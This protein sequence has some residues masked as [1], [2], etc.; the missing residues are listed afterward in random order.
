MT[1]TT[2]LKLVLTEEERSEL[3]R[4]LESCLTETRTEKRRTDT[5]QYHD[6]LAHEEKLLRELLN[7]VRNAS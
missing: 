7:K 2:E 1:T 3:L 4:V 6:E 5:P